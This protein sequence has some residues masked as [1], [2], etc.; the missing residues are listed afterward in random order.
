M[1]KIYKNSDI[2]FNVDSDK[3]IGKKFLIKFYTAN[4]NFYITHNSDEVIVENETRYIKLNW[5]ELST[6]GDGVLNYVC[7]VMDE[8]NEFDDGV[9]NDAFSRTTDYYIASYLNVDEEDAESYSQMLADFKKQANEIEVAL[10]T[11][12]ERATTTDD[13]L[14]EQ[15]NELKTN[16]DAAIEAERQFAID[17]LNTLSTETTTAI[18]AEKTR[19]TNKESEIERSIANEAE[20]AKGI[21][22]NLSDAISA[23]TKRATDKEKELSDNIATKVD[24]T[25][26]ATD[27]AAVETELNKKANIGDSYTKAESDAKYL[28]EHQS[29]NGYATEKWVEDKGYLT[30]HQDISNLATKTELATKANANDV[31]TKT[32]IDTKGTALNTSISNET[33]AREQADA[34]LQTNIE[35]LSTSFDNYK[36]DL[37]NKEKTISASLNDLKSTKAD[38][39][40]L[41]IIDCGEY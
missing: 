24:K 40:D 22:K 5:S 41:K 10:E 30:K 8:D 9:Y 35:T 28:T 21:E 19:A 25:T 39:E 3:R 6:I 1:K 23:E 20:R 16:H 38:K 2:K 4:K 17:G 26:Y 31:Y 32:E 36:Q 33:S 13:G 29:L 11:E 27:K 12:V 37:E 14:Q 15:I 34:T 7:N 18:Q